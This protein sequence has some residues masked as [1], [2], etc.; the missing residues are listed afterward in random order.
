M[1]VPSDLLRIVW[2]IVIKFQM[3]C[4]SPPGPISAEA[5]QGRRTLFRARARGYDAELVKMGED[6]GAVVNVYRIS[7]HCQPG[8]WHSV[9]VIR[10]D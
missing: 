10:L 7:S 3:F 5:E 8:D 9:S 4:K 1:V 2:L 6:H